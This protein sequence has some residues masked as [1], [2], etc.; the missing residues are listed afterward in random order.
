MGWLA[1]PNLTLVLVAGQAIAFV[2]HS[3]GAISIGSMLLVPRLV[4]QGEI[5]RLFSFVFIP[6]SLHPI[7][8]L[9]GL[10]IFYLMGTALEGEWGEFRYNLFLGTGYLATVAVS[11]VTMD[12]ASSVAY[13]GGM[14][15]LAFAYLFPDFEIYLF[16]ILPVKVRWLALF[17]WI[18]YAR[19]FVLGTWP[20]R[21]QILAAT[22]NFFLFFGGD[23]LLRIRSTRR[24]ATVEAARIARENRPRHVCRICGVTDRMDPDMDFRYCTDCDPVQ[25][26]CRDHIDDHPHVRTGSATQEEGVE[27]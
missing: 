3:I 19:Q 2:L 15:F 12:D 10:Y 7:F 8:I 6:P 22:A 11:F 9:F 1:V 4:L 13:L 16:F 14:I 26:Y 18:L 27:R 5:W 23:L 24:R 25:C 17:T 21:L 20:D